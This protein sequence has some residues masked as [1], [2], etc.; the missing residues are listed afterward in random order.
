MSHLA[1]RYV[2][3]VAAVAL[4]I[5]RQI[6]PDLLP[7]DTITIALLIVAILPWIE[8]IVSSAEFPGGWRV[9]FRELKA[10]TT[11]LQKE[12]ESTRRRIDDLVITSI[13]PRTLGNLAKIASGNFKPYFLGTGLSRE[14]TYLE[15]IGYISFKCKGIDDIPQ[16]GH[17]PKELNLADFVQITPF[18]EEYIALREV[19]AKRKLD[20]AL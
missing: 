10:E 8:F 20:N 12:V 15:N 3:T 11:K 1:S 13:S 16:N 14:L 17:E 4:I 19:I 2:I 7:D 9:Q 18:G 5:V 6:R